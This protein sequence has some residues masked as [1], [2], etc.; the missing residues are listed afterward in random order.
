LVLDLDG[1]GIESVGLNAINPLMFDLTGTGVKTSVGWIKPDD[2]FLV[3]DRN[4]NGTIDG[5]AE[6]FGDATPLSGGGTA[7]NGFT[8]LT[9]LD[10]LNIAAVDL[11]PAHELNTRSRKRHGYKTP[12]EIYHAS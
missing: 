3:L 1:D 10:S 8:A 5:G 9:D 6:L 2:G 11:T 12:L 7:S 4:G